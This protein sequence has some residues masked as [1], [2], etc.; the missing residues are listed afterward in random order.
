MQLNDPS[1]SACGDQGCCSAASLFNPTYHLQ[2]EHLSVRA[3][4]EFTSWG[5]I[6]V[7]RSIKLD[8]IL[9]PHHRRR[10]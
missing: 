2:S 7:I 1:F 10:I 4:Y 5:V 9:P 3:V 6:K 8:S